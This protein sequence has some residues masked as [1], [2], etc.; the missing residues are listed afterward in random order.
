MGNPII[1]SMFPTS[2]YELYNERLVA[3]Q[4]IIDCIVASIKF[5]MWYQIQEGFAPYNFQY[6]TNEWLFL[7][8]QNQKLR[9]IDSVI[10]YFRSRGIRCYLNNYQKFNQTTNGGSPLPGAYFNYPTSM[11]TT[12]YVEWFVRQGQEYM[13]AYL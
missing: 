1:D 12:L 3:D 4:P 13:K 10:L 2:I 8:D 6:D 11:T 5:Q 9:V 7:S